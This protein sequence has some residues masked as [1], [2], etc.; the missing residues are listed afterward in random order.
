[1]KP[2]VL[3]AIVVV[4]FA[5]LATLFLAARKFAEARWQRR[6]EAMR[7]ALLC[8]R[9][10]EV[11]H[12]FDPHD[13][14]GLP[15]PVQRYFRTVLPEGQPSIRRAHIVWRGEMNLGKPGKDNWKPFEATQD[16]VPSA[17][18]FLWA[19]RV[20]V[21]PATTVLV[22]DAFIDG[23]GSMRGAV[24]GL[25]PVVRS[26]GTL[27]IANSALQRYLGEAPWFPTALLPSE[28]VVWTTL[29]SAR[30]VATLRGGLTT[31]SVDFRFADD[32]TPHSVHV[33]DRL[34]DKGRDAP[35]LRPWQ[36]RFLGFRRWHGLLVPDGA[37][38]EWLLPTGAF[39]YWRA[40]PTAIEYE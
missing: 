17:P 20:A 19:A 14:A 15:E 28:G 23:V 26:E 24:F 38:V 7:G 30:A 13:L 34:Y 37:I 1:M 12:I 40:R 36:G 22:R 2:F 31:V 11:R 9:A 35:A 5:V 39:A 25:V 33:P 4:L 21:G 32:G 29:D 18:G 8:R 27:E 10:P 6:T 16:Y 3:L